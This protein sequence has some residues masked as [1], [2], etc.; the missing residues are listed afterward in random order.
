VAEDQGS[1]QSKSQRL[2]IAAAIQHH[3]DAHGLAR[4]DLIRDYLSK[5]TID[6]LFQGEFSERTLTK[7]EA[8]LNIALTPKHAEDD[9]APSQIGGYTL[10]AVDYLQGDYLCV[11]PLFTD[12]TNLN[13]YL[14]RIAWDGATRSLRFEELSRRDA[15]YAQKGTVY[16]PFGTPFLNL[17]STHLG[18]LRTV[19]LSL[20][21]GEGVCRGL[22][23]TLSNPKGT[24]YTPVAAPVF[25][26]RLATNEQPEV[27]FIKP[28][29]AS[30]APY[31]DVLASVVADEFGRFVPAPPAPSDRRR[32]V[33][34]VK[35]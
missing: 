35:P 19:L 16:I 4:K 22:I 27:G 31:L 25:L 6:K 24:M 1:L 2:A 10:Q 8:I 12:P 23:T 26:R 21:D 14:I 9:Q 5:S 17:V 34:A 20:P 28:D 33:A 11:R 7:I 30:Y 29:S 32:A 13:A 3:L 15:K 18:N